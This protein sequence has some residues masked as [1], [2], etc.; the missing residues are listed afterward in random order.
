MLVGFDPAIDRNLA[1]DALARLRLDPPRPWR[2][3]V[4]ESPTLATAVGAGVLLA[5]RGISTGEA[6]RHL[7]PGRLLGRVVSS[8]EAA[9]AATGADFL[10]VDPPPGSATT[11]RAVVEAAWAPV[12]ARVSLDVGAIGDRLAGL[13]RAGVE[14]V[15]IVAGEDAEPATIGAIVSA[16]RAG[17]PQRW[18]RPDPLATAEPI[19]FVDGLAHPLLPD[20]AVTD[21][22]AD[23]GRLD[24]RS[25]SIDGRPLPRRRWDDTLLEPG[26]Q[27][28]IGES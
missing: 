6:R 23:F 14:G 19:V 10:V 26:V 7:A 3:I 11:I 1:V 12:L 9:S 2:I 22:L 18:F 20:T 25:V 4:E 16:V 15:V 13:I 24:A 5:E 17:L 27:V 21:L 28:R 8:P